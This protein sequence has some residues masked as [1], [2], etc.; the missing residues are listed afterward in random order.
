MIW[1]YIYQKGNENQIE[2][3][4]HF[5]VKLAVKITRKKNDFFLKLFGSLFQNSITFVTNN[6]TNIVWQNVNC[7]YEG[8][9]NWGIITAAVRLILLL[10]H[11]QITYRMPL[12]SSLSTLKFRFRFWRSRVRIPPGSLLILSPYKSKI[13]MDF[14]F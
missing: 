6:E 13:Y 2:F 14:F 12:K 5:V 8:K 11:L 10:S 7:D 3:E 1:F 4:M 9:L